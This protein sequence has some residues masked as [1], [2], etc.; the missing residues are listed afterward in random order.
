MQIYTIQRG[1]S[2][3]AIARTFNSSVNDIVNANRIPDPERL[4][5]GQTIV[6]PITGRYYFVQPGDSLWS[7]GRR[8]N[9]NYLTLAQINRINPSQP[10]PV[11]LRL[12]IPPFPKVSAEVNAYIEPMGNAPSQ[13][14]LADAREA[15]PRLTYLATFSYRVNRDG[16]LN[17]PPIQGI[18]EIARQNGN[19]LMM[20][21]TNIEE[22]QFNGELGRSI[23]E[24]TAVQE[25]LFDNIIAEARRTGFR[26]IH[27]DFEFLPPDLRVLYTEF[28]RRA[29]NRLHAEGLLV[30][31]ALAPKTSAEQ[32]GQWYEAHD[33]GAIGQIV[34]F[35]VIMTYEWGY[36]GGPPM[37]VSPIDKVEEVL[38][39]ALTEIPANKILMGQNLYGYDWTLPFVQGGPFARAVSPQTA[40]LLARDNNAEILFDQ[41][42]QAPHFNYF[43]AQGRE[44]KVWFE[45]ARSIQAKFDL[46]K[47]LG[48]RGISYW[49]LGLPFPQNW[50]LIDE[51]FNVVKR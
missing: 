39:Y 50:L 43:D 13:S 41:V 18:P 9:V 38:R 33:Y 46:I 24:S 45:D 3:Y 14:L 48:L 26:D 2:L 35:V 6:I 40:I 32:T 17:P 29:V 4:V 15:A 30:S 8:F 23:I 28:L 11:G 22:G 12:Y 21:V 7:I 37:A 19:T 27:F 34:D 49:K 16:T 36:S 1:D 10:L 47:E 31:A 51:N 44:H 5:V 20:V 42:A 25:L